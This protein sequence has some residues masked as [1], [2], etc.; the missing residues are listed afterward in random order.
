MRKYRVTLLYSFALLVLC[1]LSRSVMPL[2]CAPLWIMIV[3]N[4]METS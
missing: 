3:L 2:V 1:L 4:D